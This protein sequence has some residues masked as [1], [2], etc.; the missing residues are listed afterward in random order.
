MALTAARIFTGRDKIITFLGGYHGSV[1]SFASL[2][3]I[4]SNAPYPFVICQYNDV[5][6]AIAAIHEHADDLAAVILEPMLGGGGGIVASTPFLS[7]LRDVTRQVGALLIFDEVMTS[8]M[9]GGGVQSRVGITPDLTALGKY[10]GGGMSFGAF[11]G[12][13][14]IMEPFAGKVA[15]PEPST[16]L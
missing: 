9:S 14:D 10:M 13:A 7:A 2:T 15:M 4:L 16:T 3:P 8:R 6:G 11:G 5:E 1:I 12:R